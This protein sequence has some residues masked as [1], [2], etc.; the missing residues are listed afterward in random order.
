MADM[1]LEPTN[2]ELQVEVALNLKY[3]NWQ[4]EMVIS[5]DF[6]RSLRDANKRI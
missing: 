6:S 3:E 4:N 5:V 2:S 1:L